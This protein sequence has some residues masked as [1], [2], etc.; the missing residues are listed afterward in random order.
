M[1][2]EDVRAR[3]RRVAQET[4][5]DQQ[6][7]C[8]VDVLLG[9]RWLEPAHVDRWRQGRVA[10]LEEEIQTN[11][12]KVSAAMAELF[13]WARESGLAQSETAYVA[14]THDRHPL[15]FSA[16]GDAETERAYRT[17]WVSPTLSAAKRE[18]LVEK[19]N[20]PADLVVVAASRAWTC[21][22]CHDESFGGALLIMEEAGPLC[23]DCAD[24]G[25][26]EYLPAGDAALTRRAKELSGLSAVVVRWS[27]AR[28][29]YE[30][31]GLLVESAAL[32][33]AGG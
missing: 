12:V 9:L 31:Q 8:P 30:R 20:R 27:R 11:P 23:M 18:R 21:A 6:Y 1:A 15:R 4:L 17:L 10:Y 32:E 29:R 14:R 13:R 5:A 26:L 16:R 3:V 28:K 19:L 33:K 24:L 2:R 7:V 25:H 22:K